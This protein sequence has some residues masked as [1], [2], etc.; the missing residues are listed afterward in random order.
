MPLQE[1]LNLVVK[2]LPWVIGVALTLAVLAAVVLIIILARSKKTGKTSP[3]KAQDMNSIPKQ[4]NTISLEPRPTPPAGDDQFGLQ[5]VMSNGTVVQI[6]KMPALIGR[7]PTNDIILD[8]DTIS[9]T[10]ARIFYDPILQAVCIEDQGSLN[11]V[12]VNDKP[13]K[14]NILSNEDRVQM[15]EITLIFQDTGYIPPAN[16]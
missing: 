10:H 14:M 6:R 5:L 7:A 3:Q 2:Y 1:I 16:S 8:D 4:P 12:Y 11:G 9:S 13:T 15:G